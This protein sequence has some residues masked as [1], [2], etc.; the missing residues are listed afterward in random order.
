LSPEEEKKLRERFNARIQTRD[1]KA[2]ES[3]R[4]YKGLPD[5]IGR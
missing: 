4:Y 3:F 1:G 2:V 5:G